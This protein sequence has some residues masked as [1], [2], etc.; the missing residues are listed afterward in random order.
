MIE[1]VVKYWWAIMAIGVSPMFGYAVA[2]RVKAV[3]PKPSN[4][5]IINAAGLSTAISAFGFWM[6]YSG[7]LSQSIMMGVTIGMMQLLMVR[8][9][10]GLLDRFAPKVADRMAEGTDD[11]STILPWAAKKE[12]QK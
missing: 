11:S 10:F 6:E 5:V 8:A 1:F 3:R 9:I 2:Q 7:I 12:K 4:A